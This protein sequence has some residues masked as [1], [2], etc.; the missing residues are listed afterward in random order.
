MCADDI[1]TVFSSVL[2][3]SQSSFRGFGRQKEVSIGHLFSFLG[4][5]IPRFF[6]D[7]GTGETSTT[8]DVDQIR[9]NLMWLCSV[10][11]AS[12]TTSIV[13]VNHQATSNLRGATYNEPEI[14]NVKWVT[15]GGSDR[16]L[17]WLYSCHV[18]G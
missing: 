16:S 2:R 12:M 5:E 8:R 7:S 11:D 18:N 17:D 13:G 1:P 10:N 15:I 6:A 14:M 9:T 3:F 4:A